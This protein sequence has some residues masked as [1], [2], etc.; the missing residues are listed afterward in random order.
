MFVTFGIFLIFLVAFD[1][2][3]DDDRLTKQYFA[4]AH[5]VERRAHMVE[6]RAHLVERRD[7]F[8]RGRSSGG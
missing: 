4:R 1:V 2:V 3:V 8:D 7:W 5:T 6:R